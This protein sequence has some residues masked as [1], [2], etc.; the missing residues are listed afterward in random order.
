MPA[1]LADT[2]GLKTLSF[3]V[4]TTVFADLDG[5]FWIMPHEVANQIFHCLGY[6]LGVSASVWRPPRS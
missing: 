5:R 4:R 3:M 2:R 6:G 1:W